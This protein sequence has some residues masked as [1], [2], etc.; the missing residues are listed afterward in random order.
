MD[1]GYD[2][3]K[4]TISKAV[5]EFFINNLVEQKDK[6]WL[7]KIM[8]GEKI[9]GRKKDSH[10]ASHVLLINLL[11]GLFDK[12]ASGSD[13]SMEITPTAEEED[14]I[15]G[16]SGIQNTQFSQGVS[17]QDP[18]PNSGAQDPEL[19]R[20]EKFENAKLCKFYN[21]G[22]CTKDKNCKFDHPQICKVFRKFGLK[23]NNDKGCE[24]SCDQ[25]HPNT[26]RDSLKSKKCSRP[27][28][29]FFHLKDTKSIQANHSN[30]GTNQS[31]Y[32]PPGSREYGGFK[33]KN[34]FNQAQSFETQNRFGPLMDPPRPQCSYQAPNAN[35][36]NGNQVFQGDSPNLPDTLAA[37]MKQLMEINQRQTNLEQ[38]FQ[39]HN[40]QSQSSQNPWAI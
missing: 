24:N 30:K 1:L 21:R 2:P 18:G 26:C 23:K 6:D 4:Q 5:G 8:V 38:K 29:R 27:D 20:K 14:P 16:M 11:K 10:K 34:Q 19:N 35:Q 13:E 36:Q 9:D 40:S 15:Q 22:K 37:I 25:F 33:N 17:T 12:G 28:C 39:S 3:L 7:N 31:Q 32:F